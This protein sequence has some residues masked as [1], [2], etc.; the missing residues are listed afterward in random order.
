MLFG[1]CTEGV[2]Q[3]SDYSQRAQTGT[4]ALK[5]WGALQV[6]NILDTEKKDLFVSLA[7]ISSED[8]KKQSSNELF[9][10]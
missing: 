7:T 2:L 8:S 9:H 1:T 4:G 5:G 10:F 6:A 3:G